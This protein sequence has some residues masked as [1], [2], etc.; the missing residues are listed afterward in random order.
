MDHVCVFT[1]TAASP[2][3][4]LQRKRELLVLLLMPWSS[5]GERD[6]HAGIGEFWVPIGAQSRLRGMYLNR[7]QQQIKQQKSKL[8]EHNIYFL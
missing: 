2:V 1:F 5:E 7:R 3:P 6:E 8:M 4:N